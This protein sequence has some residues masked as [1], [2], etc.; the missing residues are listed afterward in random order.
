MEIFKSFS[1]EFK[2]DLGSGRRLVFGLGGGEELLFFQNE[3]LAADDSRNEDFRTSF[4]CCDAVRRMRIG[5][6]PCGA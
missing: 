4:V 3:D 1:T 2:S 6:S 5:S